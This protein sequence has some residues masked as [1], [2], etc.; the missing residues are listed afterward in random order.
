LAWGLPLSACAGRLYKQTQ[1]PGHGRDGR[2]T[3]GRSRPC[4]GTPYGVTTNRP[5]APNK[6]NFRRSCGRGK[7][8]A[9]KEL[10]YIVPAIGFG[11]TKPICRT[12]PR[13]TRDGGA[14]SRAGAAAY[15]AKQTQFAAAGRGR[16]SPRPE[17][18]TLPPTGQMCETKPILRLR[19]ADCRN[20]TGQRGVV[21]LRIQDRPAARRQ[22]LQGRLYK[23]SQFRPLRP[24]RDPIIPLFHH[25][26]IPIPRPSCETNPGARSG[27]PRR[28]PARAG[29]ASVQTNPISG[30]WSVRGIPS[31]PLF[32]YSSVPVPCPI[33]TTPPV[34]LPCRCEDAMVS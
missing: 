31:I 24:S 23:Q 4:Y 29:G 9:G 34:R 26:T 20:G 22:G 3:H 25:S 16:P 7:W 32:H 14:S 15:C 27:A 6:A 28:C 21:G 11:K 18:L 10:W 19:I 2:G 17:A 33:P 30:S 1:F 12:G 8:L 5:A 13:G